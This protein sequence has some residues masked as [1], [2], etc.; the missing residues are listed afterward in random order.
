MRAA[1]VIR[2]VCL[3]AAL[4]LSVSAVAS[5]SCFAFS[6]EARAAC[7]GDAF[8]LCSSE[9]PSIPKITVC[10]RAN[11]AKLSVPCR[12]VMEK[13]DVPPG[14]DVAAAKQ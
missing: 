11:K 7:T 9:I 4:A 8:R 12:A 10:M 6:A 1:S 5:S 13:E 3:S 14:A 2:N